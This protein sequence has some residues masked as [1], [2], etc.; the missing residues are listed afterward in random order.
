MLHGDKAQS[1]VLQQTEGHVPSLTLRHCTHSPE[2]A[3]GV[4][5]MTAK[6][7]GFTAQLSRGGRATKVD[8]VMGF[9]CLLITLY[10]LQNIWHCAMVRLCPKTMFIKYPQ[11]CH[12]CV[13]YFFDYFK[14]ALTV[15]EMRFSVGAFTG[16][17]RV[18]VLFT[19]LL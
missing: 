10:K 18:T 5:C 6:H 13:Y 11:I 8:Q 1:F 9:L 7:R 14:V 3:L 12:P 17:L 4:T 19:Y 16:Y 2:D 15:Q